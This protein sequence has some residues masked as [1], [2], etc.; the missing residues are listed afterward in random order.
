MD[1]LTD[2]PIENSYNQQLFLVQSNNSEGNVKYLV[3]L[4]ELTCTCP[5]AVHKS[6]KFVRHMCKH[7]QH[8]LNKHG[9]K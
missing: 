2:T 7:L 9:K 4:S 3:N 1:T 6:T 8:C 5:A